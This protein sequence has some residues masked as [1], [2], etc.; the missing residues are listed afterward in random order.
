MKK[1]AIGMTTAGLAFTSSLSYANGYL[2]VSIGSTDYGNNIS[3][4]EDGDSLALTG[5]VRVSPNLAFEASYIDLG[6]ASDNIPPSWTVEASGLNF[7]A[8]GIAPVS[9]QF[10]IFGKVGLFSWD[11][12]LSEAGFGEFAS[13]S[14]TDFSLGFG[15]TFNF[16]QQFGAVV[17]YQMF[18]L[19]GE[20]VDNLSFGARVNF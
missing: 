7:A 5:G 17:E 8:V 19:D 14:G 9:P 10:D 20:D 12:S 11:A 15:A 16:S 3:Y 6:D 4:F 1:I 18:D 13:D 2:G